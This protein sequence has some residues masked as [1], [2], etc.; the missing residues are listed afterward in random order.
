ML[1]EIL[2]D[3]P[4]LLMSEIAWCVR[5]AVALTCLLLLFAIAIALTCL[6]LLFAI[7]IGAV[8]VC[9]ARAEGRDSIRARQPEPLALP[10]P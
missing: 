8:G 4:L 7:A 9:V 5:V 10:R 3:I 1:L 2:F 6:L